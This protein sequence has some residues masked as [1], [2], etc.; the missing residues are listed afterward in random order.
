[1]LKKLLTLALFCLL[2]APLCVNAQQ[3]SLTGKVTDANSGDEL[4]GASVYVVEL[5]RGTSSDISGDYSL[6]LLPTGEYTIRVTYVGYRQFRTTVNLQSGENTL[7]VNMQPD[8]FG[9]DEIVVTGVVGDTDS[10]KLPFTVARVTSRDLELVPSVSAAGAI[11][12]KIPG[13]TMVQGSGQPGSGTSVVL[14]GATSITG[15]NQPLYIVDGVILGA[16]NVDVEALDIESVEVIKG[17]AAASMYGSRAANGVINIQT[18]RGRNLS[19]GTTRITV[20]NEFGVNQL[21]NK[22]AVN[23]SH[24]YLLSDDPDAPWVDAD[25]N[26]TASRTGR[27][28]E[29]GAYFLDKEYPTETFDHLDRFFDPGSFYTN[30]VSVSQRIGAT[31]YTASFNNTQDTGVMLNLEGYNRKN[32]RLNL[33]SRLLN[34]L[35][36]SASAY[37]AISELDQVQTGP[38]SP[39]F[40]LVFTDVDVDLN[41]RDDNGRYVIQPDPN[42]IEENPLYDVAYNDRTD[43]RNRVMGSFDLRYNP[44]QW[45]ELAGNFSYDRSNRNATR[46]WPTWWE[47]VDQNFYEGGGLLIDDRYDEAINASLTATVNQDFGDLATRTQFR[48]LQESSEFKLHQT[49]GRNFAVD[50]VPRLDITDDDRQSISSLVE[51]V[52]AEGYYLISNLDYQGKYIVDVMGRRDGSSLFGEDE[53]WHNYYRASAAYRISEEDFFDVPAIDELKLR[54]SIGTAGGRPSF[55]AQYE[56]WAV[57]GSSVTKGT[58]GN[59]SLRPEFATETEFGIELGLYERLLLDVTYARTVTEDQILVLPLVGYFGFSSQWV[60]AG[61]LESNTL[62]ASLRAFAV[63][64]RD[65]SLSFNLLYDRSNT[66]ITEFNRPAQRHGPGTQGSDVFYRRSGE[67]FGTF[68]GTRWITN[69]S[70]LQTTLGGDYSDYFDKNDDGYLVPVGRGNNWQSGNWGESIVADDGTVLGNFGIPKGFVDEDGSTFVRLGRALPKFNMAFSSNFRYRG[71]TAYALFDGQFGGEIYNQTRQWTTRDERAGEM[72]QRGKPEAEKK[73]AAYYIHLYHVNQSNSHYVEDGTYVKLR[74]VALRY[75]FD[76]AALSPFFGDAVN[77][78]SLSLIGRNLITWT[79]Y[80]G[81]DPEVGA[82]ESAILR[83]DGFNYPNF[84]T[85]TG[86]LEIQF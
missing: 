14:R 74:E 3:A 22:V 26:A 8:L 40:G 5:E 54:A 23:N 37:Y 42:N 85:I 35:T 33:D 50:G 53:R 2:T 29:P 25:G 32:A 36:L 19:D 12:G 57:S 75:R 51:E 70:D 7:N 55:S 44:V 20:R 30:Y 73:P 4:P 62:E 80:T 10:K 59:K 45:L 76:H 69:N 71:L 47:Q 13:V 34:N 83:F 1:M 28:Q 27:E 63:Q 38:G 84:R 6:E 72:D 81:F 9:L 31:N 48:V 52:R 46:F 24:A 61:T 78:I 58:L 82:G 77:S 67:E 15:S 16:S 86:S 49:E 21:A 39:F 41:A 65:M 43:R 68:Y 66:T 18:K 60:N 56:V 17:A 64:S 79:N 11:R